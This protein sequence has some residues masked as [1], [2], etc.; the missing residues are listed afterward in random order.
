MTS[1]E[2]AESQEDRE[3][4]IST[5]AGAEGKQLPDEERKDVKNRNQDFPM[6][7]SM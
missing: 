3:C 2:A 4:F 6:Q 7:V 5:T 1:V